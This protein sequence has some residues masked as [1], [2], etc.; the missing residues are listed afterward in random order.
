MHYVSFNTIA[1]GMLLD[2]P[3]TEVR[4]EDFQ[5]GGRLFDAPGPGAPPPR[6]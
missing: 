2:P 3:F 6:A 4:A 5:P 1:H